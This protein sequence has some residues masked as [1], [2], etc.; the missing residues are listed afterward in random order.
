MTNGEQWARQSY[1]LR[2]AQKLSIPVVDI[3]Y[4]T[5]CIRKGK[6]L[7]TF[8]FAPRTIQS[9]VDSSETLDDKP[10]ELPF[11]MYIF[12]LFVMCSFY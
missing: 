5:A 10:T 12:F 8:L 4:I 2:N 3:S 6:I 11:G 1:K 7:P 9:S